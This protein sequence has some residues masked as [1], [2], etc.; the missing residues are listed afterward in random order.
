MN[1]TSHLLTTKKILLKFFKSLR[2]LE[3]SPSEFDKIMKINSIFCKFYL[4]ARI[5]DKIF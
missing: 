1:L 5:V 4:Y 2:L 3:E